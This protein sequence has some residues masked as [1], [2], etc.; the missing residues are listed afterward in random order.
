MADIQS[1]PNQVQGEAAEDAAAVGNPVLVG[2]RFDS[3]PRSLETGD[4][5]AIALD[6]DG[7]VQVADGGN[8][9]TVDGTVTASNAAGDIAHDSSDS[10]NPVKTGSKAYNFDGTEPGTAVAEGDRTHNISDLYG[11]P[12]VEITHPRFWSVSADYA[13]AQTNTSVKATPGASLKLYLTDII[14]SNGATAGNITLLNGSGGAVLLELYPA[15][16]GGMTSSF[17]TP[18]ALSADTAL[19]ITSTTVTTHTITICGF[20]AP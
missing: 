20:I 3:S 10:G 19:C 7:A 11:R 5:G 15:V 18:I 14:I 8:S 12:Y 17:R 2:G 13:S 16:N 1:A 6:A 4:V 9:L